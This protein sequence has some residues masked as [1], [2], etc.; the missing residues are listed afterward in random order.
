MSPNKVDLTVIIPTFNEERNIENCIKSVL[1]ANEIIIAD[2]S[3][4]DRTVEIAKNFNARIL[5]F[6]PEG[7]ADPI[8]QK[9]VYQAKNDWILFLDADEIIPLDLAK[10]M[11][12][13]VK[14]NSD[15][16]IIYIPRE[17]YFFGQS[18]HGAGWGVNQDILPRMF[19]KGAIVFDN[20]IHGFEHP[21]PDSKRM[22]ISE[23]FSLHIIHFN[24]ISVES[25]VEKLNRYTTIGS[26]LRYKKAK[27]KVT[28][29]KIVVNFLYEFYH[30]FFV[31][32]GYKEGVTGFVM[33]AMMSFYRITEDFKLYLM[34]MLG[35]ENVSETVMDLYSLKA[36]DILNE[37]DDFNMQ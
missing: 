24:Y 1:W 6:P 20:Q 13:I 14:N 10:K 26:R 35:T 8:R 21:V 17:N 5:N 18:L 28:F 16:D 12:E 15:F 27:K 37:Y 9:A 29:S 33:S 7:Y 25:F 23:D 19:R 34:Q 22:L 11:S 4:T 30:R 36:K 2:G 32:K 31:S 3:S